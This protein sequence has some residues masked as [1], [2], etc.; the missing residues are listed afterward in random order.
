MS[1]A[2]KEAMKECGLEELLNFGELDFDSSI[3]LNTGSSSQTT[4]SQS[5][6]TLNYTS[7]INA[8]TSHQVTQTAPNNQAPIIIR[9]GTL[10]SQPQIMAPQLH[11]NPTQTRPAHSGGVI[12]RGNA[13][14]Q[15]LPFVCQPVVSSTASISQHSLPS[16]NGRIIKLIPKVTQ[17]SGTPGPI[18]AL[19]NNGLNSGMPLVLNPTPIITQINAQPTNI[20]HITRQSLPSNTKPVV[21]L[22]VPN[23]NGVLRLSVP[24][25]ARHNA[26]RPP[27]LHQNISFSSSG[28]VLP[29][30]L[31]GNIP[32]RVISRPNVNQLAQRPVTVL[33]QSV[34]SL[35][36]SRFVTPISPA[37]T[38][39]LTQMSKN[40]PSPPSH[41]NSFTGN[42]MITSHYTEMV[43][44]PFLNVTAS[45]TANIFNTSSVQIK[46]SNPTDKSIDVASSLPNSSDVKLAISSNPV[47][48][49]DKQS[50][51]V[52][53]EFEVKHV[54]GRL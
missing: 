15:S 29:N 37:S 33:N 44:A 22:P 25:A 54:S 14:P 1:D 34:A 39:V 4:L 35:N 13:R 6:P 3:E 21:Q 12:L 40:T 42:Q 51:N 18:R 17:S 24:A 52:S 38:V 23:Q 11:P 53:A 20:R 8:F 7:S 16:Q 45:A 46:T 2:I 36:A 19:V 10:P 28:T 32:F 41:L 43:K 9:L 49:I 50:L 27:V 5:P 30:N 48:S 47:T 26:T 31:P